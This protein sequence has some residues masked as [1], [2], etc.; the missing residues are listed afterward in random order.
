MTSMSHRRAFLLVGL[1]L[2]NS[3]ALV[4]TAQGAQGRGGS[5]DDFLVN[6]ISVGNV[7][8]PTSVWIQPD[9]AAMPYVFMDESVEIT[10]EVRRLG[11]AQLG[12][13]APV[14]LEV[15][16]PIG[17][18]MQ[19]W[20]WDTSEL[21]GSIGSDTNSVVW[22]PDVAH[23]ILNTSTNELHGGLILRASVDYPQDDRNE[24]DVKEQA[25]P[26]AIQSDSMDGIAGT[27]L[28]F[29]P[30]RYQVNG[31]G[32]VGAGSWTT[33]GT[34]ENNSD[35][36]SKHW[37][38]SQPGSNYPSSAYDRLVRG[39][40]TTTQDCGPNAAL[41]GELSYVYQIYACRDAFYAN[42]FISTQFHVR[43]WGAT[44]NGDAVSIELW[45]P[46]GRYNDPM[47][48]LHWN[49]TKGAPASGSGDWTNLSWDPQ[50]DWAQIPTLSN[51][52]IFLG[53]NTWYYGLL[54]YSDSSGASEGMH[55]DD[56]I[57]FGISKVDEFTLD[58][59]CNNPE[60][61]FA[62][63]PNG[64]LVLKCDVTNNGYKPAPV[65]VF[66]EVSNASWMS[67]YLQIRIDADLNPNDHDNNVILQNFDAGMTT[68]VWLNL[69]IP[70]GSDV[71]QQ[72][73]NVTF[74]DHTNGEMKG[75][76]TVPVGVTEQH[77]V[78]L[79]SNTALLA[80]TLLPGES[81]LI[82][83]RLQNTGNRDANYRLSAVF[84]ESDWTGLVVNDTGA[85]VPL[86]INLKKGESMNLHLNV[87]AYELATPG[88][89][90]FNLRATCPTCSGA[91]FGTDVLVRNVEVPVLRSLSF[92]TED[93]QISGL[94][95][96]QARVVQLTLL[97]TGNAEEQYTLELQ[98]VNYTIADLLTEQT[99]I[100][101]AWDGEASVTLRLNMP[102]GLEPGFYTLTVIARNMADN[103]VGQS[104][105][106]SLEILDTAAVTVL[107]EDADQ[108]YIPGDPP[109]FMEFEIRNDGNKADR[110]NMSLI[111]PDGMIADVFEVSPWLV[112]G[113]TWKATVTFSFVP[114]TEGQLQLGVTATSQNDPSISA[115][116]NALYR[117]GSQN[118]LRIPS[119]IPLE[120]DT[121][122]ADHVM[123][124]TV[125]N[126]YTTAQ[127]VAM[128]LDDGEAG[129]YMLVRINSQDQ[130][131]VLQVGEERKVTV[132]LI[133]S[134]TTLDNLDEDRKT[135]NFTIWA[136][137][138]TVSDAADVQMTV[139][140][141]R[142][143]PVDTT[144][145]EA[146][147]SG[148]A[149]RNVIM[150]LLTAGVVV[151]G[152]LAVMRIIGG[153]EEDAIDDWAD[154][155]YEDSLQ[156]TYA[157]VKAA[158][159]IPAEAPPAG[160]PPAAPA[161]AA[162]EAPAPAPAAAPAAPPV[163]AEGLPEGWSMEQWQ[164]YGQMW[165]EQNGRA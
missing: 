130:N 8:S 151:I 88:T 146:E 153:I 64:L 85:I 6:T 9:G 78:Q 158:P 119:V 92:T 104:L 11:N 132:E 5:K 147:G 139:T 60:S 149:V 122:D 38:H 62:S 112:P 26:V 80:D 21:I 116:G 120:I 72:D 44:N 31:G 28:G 77:S 150:I 97:N 23:S 2:L 15:V 57:Q 134:E 13:S 49:L 124:L 107:D 71:Q 159:V 157:G 39:F 51:P 128:D 55:V 96:G 125:R 32:A 155:G 103:T 43:A 19:T 45:R 93:D 165:L 69:S 110:F 100:L 160:A 48:S 136:R 114:G 66:T 61:G 50:V 118:W 1:L 35:V 75:M 63:P 46:S 152:A 144:G 129:D 14:T 101:D 47:Q 127:A 161:P 56:F 102:L 33:A 54:F 138:E 24:N 10:V 40:F 126:Q 154:D 117:V 30:G 34:D 131:F 29:I 41:D 59:D 145:D 113:E 87:T 140:M 18:V 135:V 68:S 3:L 106:I 83:F 137:S 148:G 36:G 143:A 52:D 58:V 91:L 74:Y 163:P 142:T 89:V 67:P 20:S 115:T 123:E 141:V 42:N 81:G 76:L 73:W 108:S 156:A 65:R 7:S 105:Q 86:P 27:S 99:P 16:H 25:V 94:A 4:V 133:I 70:P 121:A 82:P 53:G 111:V 22:T 37:R 95:N 164:T 17:Y 98:Q 84:S 109:Q 12:K 162:A 79:D 90:S